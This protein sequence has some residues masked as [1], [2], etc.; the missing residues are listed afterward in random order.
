[1][2]WKAWWHQPV[3]CWVSFPWGWILTN[4]KYKMGP[5]AGTQASSI[6]LPW[7]SPRWDSFFQSF[8][9]SP[10]CHALTS[11][12]LFFWSLVA[13]LVTH[14]N[15]LLHLFLCLCYFPPHDLCFQF[16]PPVMDWIVFPTPVQNSKVEV[17]WPMWLYVE[18]RPGGRWLRLDEVVGMGP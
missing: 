2:H 13:S 12:F 4:R 14:Y 11:L 8:W 6:F 9:K 7:N 16:S 1:M 10:V 17:L 15:T 18:I 3:M 5:G